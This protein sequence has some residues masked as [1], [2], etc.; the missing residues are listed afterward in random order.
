[1]GGSEAGRGELV[2]VGR[3]GGGWERG[4]GRMGNLKRG[5]DG[6]L[7]GGRGRKWKTEAWD[8]YMAVSKR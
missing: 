6:D 1:M 4:E 8:T 3:G 7:K 5:E 2:E